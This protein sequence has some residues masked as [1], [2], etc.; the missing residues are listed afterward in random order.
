MSQKRP[1][2]IVKTG[3][4]L[5]EIAERRGD[6]EK[7]IE[8][9]LGNVGLPI[10][11]QAVFGSDGVD[12]PELAS[13]AGVIVTGS[14]AMVSHEEPWSEATAAWLSGVVEAKTPC[15]GICYGHQLL[16][17]AL[18]G[19]VG[20]NPRGREI[21]TVRVALDGTR[22]DSLLEELGTAVRM[23]ASHVESVLA[24]PANAELRGTTTLD[25][26]H[27]FCVAG[28]AWGVQFHPEF[29]AD[30]MRGYIRGRRDALIEEDLDPDALLRAVE[31]TP[32]GDQ[33][34]A[35]FARLCAA[36]EAEHASA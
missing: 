13:L 14:S 7:W 21:G 24:L 19:R 26:H 16:A 31:D 32:S 34:L 9:A 18:G 1:I 36:F 30:V 6:F 20:P 22:E 8:R 28:H 25:P 5:S 15:L 4:T 3:T 10:D 29:D 27:A 2:L 23:Q 35:R 33:L 11:V 17:K 12:L